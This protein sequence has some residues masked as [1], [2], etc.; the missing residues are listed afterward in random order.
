MAGIHNAGS[1][2]EGSAECGDHDNE[3]SPNLTLGIQNVEFAGKVNGEIEQGKEVNLSEESEV[4]CEEG[5]RK[6]LEKKLKKPKKV[7]VKL[8]EEEKMPEPKRRLYDIFGG[9][10]ELNKANTRRLMSPVIGDMKTH[11][12]VKWKEP[13]E[14]KKLSVEMETFLSYFYKEGYFRDA[15]FINGKHFDVS[16]FDRK[17]ARN[18]TL[19][20][21][22]KFGN[23]KQEISK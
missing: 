23:D 20:A 21:V 3:R 12:E 2:N 17:F 19:S 8:V 14:L 6:K 4:Q 16:W 9:G 11:E 5:K 7:E 13:A 1:G 18:Y 15:N 22:H 10:E